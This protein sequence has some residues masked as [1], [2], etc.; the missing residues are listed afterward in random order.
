MLFEIGDAYQQLTRWHARTPVL[1]ME[2]VL[3]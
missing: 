1:A 3:I 2:P